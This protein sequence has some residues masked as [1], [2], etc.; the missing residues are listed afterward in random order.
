MSLTSPTGPAPRPPQRGFT[1]IELMVTVA[2]AAILVAIAVPAFNNFVLNDRDISQINSL[3]ASFNYARSE[4][5]KQNLPAGVEVC[6]SSNGNTCN[7]TPAWSGGWIVHNKDP[8]LAGTPQAV[9]QAVPALAGGN[10]VTAALSGASGI[11]FQGNGGLLNSNQLAI[12][13]CDPRGSAFAR[14]VAV[15]ATGKVAATQTA[16]QQVSGALLTCP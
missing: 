15:S 1:V 2:V 13:I 7:G 14:E 5:I 16:G 4:A 8:S 11:T 9:I 12:K 6:P 3:V 10:T